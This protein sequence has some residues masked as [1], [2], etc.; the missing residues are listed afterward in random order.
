MKIKNFKFS[1]EASFAG[2]VSFLFL[3]VVGIFFFV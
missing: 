1:E 3:F 2:W